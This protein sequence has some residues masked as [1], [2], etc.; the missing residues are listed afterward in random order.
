MKQFFKTVF[1]KGG[2]NFPS[3]LNTTRALSQN[4]VFENRA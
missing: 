2:M 1:I 3:N 4:K